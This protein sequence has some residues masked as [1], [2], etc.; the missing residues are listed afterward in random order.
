MRPHAL[1]AFACALAS[2]LAAAAPFVPAGDTEVVE[3]LPSRLLLPAERAVQRALRS[4]RIAQP[5]NL[6]VAVSA[7]RAALQRARRSGDPREL[8]EA[9]AALAPWWPLP[10]PPPAARLLRAM[11]LQGQHRFDVALRDLDTLVA[12]PGI[13]M[14]VRAQAALTR[15][16]VLQVTGR[17]AEAGAACGQLPRLAPALVHHARVCRAELAS[18]RGDPVAAATQLAAVARDTADDTTRRWVN[19]VRAELAERTG[20]SSAGAL[21][22]TALGADPD[23]YTQAALADWLLA[24]DRAADVATLLAGRED[25][26]ALLLRLAIAWR[27]AGDPRANTAAR[28][29]AERF[30]AAQVREETTHQRE[31]ARFELDVRGDAPAALPL[32]VANWAVQKEPADAL[33]LV[34]AAAA[35]GQPAAA[36]PVWRFVSATGYRDVRLDAARRQP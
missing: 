30:R 31:Q 1:A 29:L 7:A 34:R 8:G 32:A 22:R 5:A 11:V 16:T 18:L 28:T 6:P 4:Q 27:R 24:H 13:P 2:T 26:D 21:Y 10:D 9:Q 25:A 35:A 12:A 23:V 15:T 19:L 20:D 33:L 36:A 3:R 17:W 14:D